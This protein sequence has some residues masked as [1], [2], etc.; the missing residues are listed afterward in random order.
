[1]VEK[2]ENWKREEG[3]QRVGWLAE[4]PDQRLGATC[5]AAPQRTQT[6][7]RALIVSGSEIHQSCGEQLFTVRACP[8]S[9][10]QVAARWAS[11]VPAP[12]SGG[13]FRKSGPVAPHQL[14]QSRSSNLCGRCMPYDSSGAS[15]Q[16][17]VDR[18][19]LTK[20]AVQGPI[21]YLGAGPVA[22]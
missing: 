20:A 4:K 1:M 22:G 7:L 5:S 13:G 14:R 12:L 8:G 19:C 11:S 10:K 9:S 3:V 16:V 17:K 2:C 15:R 6:V 18:C 21:Q